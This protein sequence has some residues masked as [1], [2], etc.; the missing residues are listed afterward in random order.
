MMVENG[1]M[2][3]NAL[4]C[5]KGNGCNQHEILSYIQLLNHQQFNR[6]RGIE[7]FMEAKHTITQN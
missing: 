6:P 1:V 2:T 4:M 7:V 3:L 5:L